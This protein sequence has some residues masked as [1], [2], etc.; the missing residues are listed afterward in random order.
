[1]QD[2]LFL[3]KANPF[4]RA[5]AGVLMTV[6]WAGGAYGAMKAQQLLAQFRYGT[7]RRRLLERDKR[8]SDTFAFTGGIE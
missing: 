1:M 2:D 3:R 8:L 6:G 5:L 4:L 7:A